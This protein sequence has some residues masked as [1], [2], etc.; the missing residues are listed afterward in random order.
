MFGT[1]L[2]LLYEEDSILLFHFIIIPGAHVIYTKDSL[3]FYC[4][5]VDFIAPKRCH[6]SQNQS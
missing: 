3:V 2:I 4:L 1:F 6:T 5:D